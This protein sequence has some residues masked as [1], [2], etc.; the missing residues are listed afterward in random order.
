MGA[1]YQPWERTDFRREENETI[2]SDLYDGEVIVRI[3]GRHLLD[4]AEEI[5]N[6]LRME[7]LR[8]YVQG[9]TDKVNEIK[10]VLNCRF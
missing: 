4:Q 5:Y 2:I 3:P 9:A 8:G 1:I 10:E 6:V 7:F